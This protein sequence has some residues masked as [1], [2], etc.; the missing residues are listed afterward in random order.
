LR[1]QDAGAFK[2]KLE[3]PLIHSPMP[4]RISQEN[5]NSKRNTPL[6]LHF[7]ASYKSKDLEANEVSIKR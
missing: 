5:Q 1:E 7:S 2:G 4:M 3:L 6:K